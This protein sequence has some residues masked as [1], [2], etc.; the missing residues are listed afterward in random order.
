MILSGIRIAELVQ[1]GV[2]V[3]DPFDAAQ[4]NP[5]SYNLRLGSALRTYRRFPLDMKEQNLTDIIA[6][7]ESGYVLEPGRLYLG[8]TLEWTE[9]PPPYVPWIEGRSSVGRLGLTV[10]VT[11]GFGD[12]G[13]RGQ[14]TLELT[15]VHPVRVY[16]GV[17]ICQIVYTTTDSRVKPYCGKYAGD[18]GPTAS[19]LYEELH[20]DNSHNS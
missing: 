10:H 12:A 13:F 19:R 5:N 9:T 11:A 2:L 14:W 8:S 1:D 3:V 15:A 4:L 20:G 7:P 17:R 18:R 16:A 6:I